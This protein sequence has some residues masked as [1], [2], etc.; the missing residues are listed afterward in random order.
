MRN[1]LVESG[2]ALAGANAHERS[3]MDTP[4]L[5]TAEELVGLDLSH[6]ELV[7][8]SA[9]KTGE[10]EAIT[11]QGVMGLRA[12]VM[13]AGARSLLMSLWRVPANEATVKFMAAFYANMWSQHYSKV[14]ALNRAQDAVRADP[15]FKRPIYW[16][17]WVLAGEG[18]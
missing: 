3:T 14:E 9:C 18:W 16:A 2:I 12:S 8:L 11:G 17:T 7:T 1:P 10:G 5:L 4:G 6:T 15:Q 13:G